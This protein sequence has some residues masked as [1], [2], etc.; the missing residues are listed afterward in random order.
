ME[1][2]DFYR[3]VLKRDPWASD[4]WLDYPPDRLLDLPEEGVRHCVL[5]LDQ[6]EDFARIGRLEKA[7]LWLGFV[8]GFFWATGRFTLDELKNHNRP[9]PA[10][11]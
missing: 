11:D 7:F 10:V 9:E 2:T 8:Q 6:I 3:E 1:V 5:M 4:N